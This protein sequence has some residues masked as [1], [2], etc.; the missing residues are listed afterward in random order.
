MIVEQSR[1]DAP[2]VITVAPTGAEVTR[3]DNPAVPYTPQEIADEVIEAVQA[4]ATVAHLHVRNPDGTPSSSSDLFREAVSRIRAQTSALI[5]VSTGGA[6]GMTVEERVSGLDAAPDLSSIE[7]GSLN[8]GEDLFPTLPRETVAIAERATAAGA[9]LEV[10]AFEL[11]HIDAAT[12]LHERGALPDPLRF[13]LVLGVPGAAAA[14]TRNLIALA[15]AVPSGATWGVT[16]VGRHQKQMLALAV[17][18]GADCVRVG[19]EDAVYLRR[20]VLARSNAELVA[21]MAELIQRLGRTV[22]SPKEAREI[23]RMG[24]PSAD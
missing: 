17:L 23:L 19:F 13:N 6:I 20:G 8:F 22:A 4:G 15:G 9:G 2:V 10:E 3:R 1:R 11:G 14:T 12:R 5:M 21:D 18:L 24:S 16:A 7:T